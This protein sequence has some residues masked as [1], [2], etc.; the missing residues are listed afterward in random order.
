MPDKDFVLRRKRLHYMIT[1][2]LGLTYN[3]FEQQYGFGHDTVRRIVR[4]N[5]PLTHRIAFML[6]QVCGD[7]IRCWLD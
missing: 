7:D 3:K 2:E 6:S 1:E 4:D 5:K